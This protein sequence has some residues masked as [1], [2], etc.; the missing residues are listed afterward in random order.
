MD[1]QKARDD[2]WAKFRG[3]EANSPTNPDAFRMALYG[4]DLE[5]VCYQLQA[6]ADANQVFDDGSTPL[7]EAQ[8]CELAAALIEHGAFVHAEDNYGRTCLHKLAYA[9]HPDRMGLMFHGLKANLEATDCDGRTPLLT[10]LAENQALPEAAIALLNLG[11]NPH[12]CDAQGNNALHCWAMGRANANVGMLLIKL[13]V[14][15][16]AKNKRGQTVTDLLIDEGHGDKINANGMLGSSLV[17][18][19]LELSTPQASADSR[20]RRL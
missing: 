16:A 2:Q 20:A 17:R 19:D 13:D 3:V 18:C 11:A 5:G 4:D 14:D 9:D 1:Q 15:P 6:G 12:A 10:V 7:L 8:T